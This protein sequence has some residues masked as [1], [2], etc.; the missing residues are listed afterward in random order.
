[1]ALK[2]ANVYVATVL[3]TPSEYVTGTLDTIVTDMVAEHGDDFIEASFRTNM[4]PLVARL[5]EMV[6]LMVSDAEVAFTA[7]DFAGDD[8][9][10]DTPDSLVAAGGTIT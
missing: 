3:I 6:R 5:E 8:S 9:A 1:M 10:G 4:T 2:A 7:G